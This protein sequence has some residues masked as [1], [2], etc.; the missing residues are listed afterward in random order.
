MYSVGITYFALR[1]SCLS[2]GQTHASLETRCL[3]LAALDA[4]FSAEEAASALALLALGAA[5]ACPQMGAL[6]ATGLVVALRLPVPKSSPAAPSWLLAVAVAD[7][8]PAPAPAASCC[9]AAAG[10]SAPGAELRLI[11]SCCEGA[12]SVHP[13]AVE[14]LLRIE[15]LHQTGGVARGV[16]GG[17]PPA[18]P[19]GPWWFWR[20]QS[21]TAACAMRAE[22]R[23][24][25][26]MEPARGKYH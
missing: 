22:E 7:A 3:G 19:P 20:G 11:C 8:A 12:A 23:Q 26:S 15:P 21:P 2:F 9:E 24:N 13:A 6:P 10:D 17:G 16:T 25:N 4:C 14:P 5:A 18:D 1:A